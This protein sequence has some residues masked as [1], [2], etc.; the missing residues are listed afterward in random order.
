MLFATQTETRTSTTGL[1]SALGILVALTCVFAL[2][3]SATALAAPPLISQS[4]FSSVIE[5]SA[6]I[7][8]AVDPT[9]GKTNAHFDYTTLAEYEAHAFEGAQ[10]A[11]AEDVVVPSAVKGT[12]N[13]QVGS[14]VITGVS[15]SAAGGSF[16]V[17]QTITATPGTPLAA[18]TTI[19]AVEAEPGTE[20]LKLKISKA[21]TESVPGAILSATGP[22]P[23]T[24]ALAGL[25][26]A[27]GYVFRV[28]AKKVAGLQEEAQ[29]PA[30]TFY[31][32]V[33]PPT[34]GPCPNDQLRSGAFAAPGQPGALLPDC[35]SYEL[36]SPLA[37]NG[38]DALSSKL[39]P[40]RAAA[41]GGAVVFGSTF[42]IPGG[43]GAQVL[44]FYQAA[45]GEGESG[46][47]TTGL[48]PPGSTGDRA[49]FLT[50][51]L[52]DL[53][54]TYAEARLSSVGSTAFFELHRDGSAP[55]QL[56]PYAAADREAHFGFAGASADASTIL[57]EAPTALSQEEG[58]PP[59]PGGV[60]GAPNLYAWDRASGQLHLASVMNTPEET[61]A[62]LAKGAYAGTYSWAFGRHFLREG[63]A[64]G[65]NYVTDNHAVSA[66]GS[67]IFTSRS[68]GH[69]YE[70]INPTA[71]QS[72]LGPQ[73]NCT[74]P[75]KACTL[76]ISGTHLEPPDPGG[77]QPAAFQT[78]TADGSQVFF[79]SSEKLTEDANTGPEQPPAQI[80]RATLNG[81]AAASEP[82]ED[83]LAG[84][85]ALGVAIDPKG[86]YIYW[87]DPSLG[88][89][90]RAK[91]KPDGS[92]VEGLPEPRFIEPGESEGECE[93]EVSPG[94][95]E[96]IQG[97]I[98]SA[99][100]YVAVDEGHVY[101]TNTGR[102]GG[103][104]DEPLDGGGTIGRATL[105]SGTVET[106]DPAFICGED[107]AQ[108]NKRLVSNPQ[109]I[110]VNA[111]DIYWANAAQ[112]KG[113]HKIA[114]A[115]VD[116]SEAEEDFVTPFGEFAPY[117]VALTATHLYLVVNG[118]GDNSSYIERVPLEGGES[119]ANGIGERGVR[120]LGVDSGHVYWATQSEGGGIGRFDLA[121]QNKKKEFLN[122]EGTITGLVVSGTHLYWSVNGE[123]PGNPG[124]DL[125]RYEPATRSLEDLIPDPSGNGADVRGVL[126]TSADGSY[127][128][129]AA[130]ADLDGESGEAEAG[131]CRGDRF[132]DQTGDCNIYLFHEGQITFVARV[133]TAHGGDSDGVGWLLRPHETYTSSSYSP[134]SSIVSANGATLV[135][136]SQR[137]L[138][139]YDNHGFPELYRFRLGQGKVIC[140]TCTPTA[141][142]PNAAPNYFGSLE[143]SSISPNA[144]GFG[145]VQ[146]RFA[147]TDGD[148]VFFETTEALVGSDKDGAAGCPPVKSSP[149]C[150][151]VYEWEAPETGTCTQGG[152]GYSPL[153]EGCIYLISQGT[154][155][156]PAFFADA[157]SS[158]NDVFVFSRAQLVGEDTDELLDVYDARVEGGLTSQNPISTPPCE[159]EGC[160]PAP[161]EPPAFQAPPHFAGPP[162]PTPKRCKGKGCHHKKKQHKKKQRHHRKAD[163]RLG[164]LK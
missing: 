79:T 135:F 132:A 112:D 153:N 59:I 81:E 76:D 4:S 72:L 106:I 44:P 6:T 160:T 92:G 158:G 69:L 101:W 163:H 49:H 65:G 62:K 130:N 74:E 113:R 29:G 91:L 38:N 24:A 89:I 141:A 100:R 53:S 50:G 51:Q 70:R 104:A 7:T 23:L 150:L 123:A 109:G 95:F 57:I 96:P 9:G 67:V 17:G 93:E 133:D 25:S 14:T 61:Q 73:G 88:T 159:A 144:N 119:I 22:Q 12:G 64:A 111:T 138:T 66:N 58:G 63:G 20:T 34:F 60:P 36:A 47:S 151:D 80:G 30:T 10:T 16:G 18:E 31:T 54:L 161:P 125:Y 19:T 2:A 126:G 146:P 87:A 128:Y 42:G 110:A 75:D 3:I 98:P 26:P 8:A 140:V 143:F 94:V 13:L 32:Y 5:T 121:L 122:P 45:R 162:D 11:P 90:G 117:G 71:E 77:T 152:P 148:R 84:T 131:D 120:G 86:E 115:A 114:R 102:R 116:G 105:N 1:R 68:D 107:A 41:D 124:T 15:V 137:K 155:S 33:A 55:T 48:L 46:W 156:G 118:D 147:S 43:Q 139:P 85:H 35:R 56:T 40:T 134:K 52:P 145:Q 127:V 78:A 99:P 82:K 97:P 28:V 136:R 154:D 142:A 108:P 39:G 149:S 129:F 83:F 103:E 157:S 21:A 37:K 27:T 164:G